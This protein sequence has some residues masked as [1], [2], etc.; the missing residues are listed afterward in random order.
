M[1]K[2][3]VFL[4]HDIFRNSFK[5]RSLKR[6]LPK[7]RQF[8]AEALEAR[9]LM[10]S[11]VHADAIFAPGTPTD[12]I[13]RVHDALGA[14]HQDDAFQL[15][16]IRWT[17]TASGPSPNLGD[18]VTLTWSIVADGTPTDTA[19]V[20][21]NL[22]A[23]LDGIYGGGA[24]P[25][26]TRPW[27]PIFQ[28][29]YDRWSALTG[30]NYVYEPNDDGAPVGGANSFGVLGVRGDVRI[31]GQLIDGNSGILAYNYFPSATSSLAGDMMIDTGDNFYA[32]N[33]GG[34][35]LALRN[36]L[37][38]EAGHGLGLRHTEPVDGS[39]LMEPFIN[40]GFDGPQHDDILGAHRLY[41]DANEPN[42]NSVTATDVG[43]LA[44]AAPLHIQ[45]NS[46]DD[47]GDVDVFKF[48]VF[49]AG[50][51]NATITPAGRQYSEGPQGGPYNPF[52]SNTLGD[53]TISVLDSTGNVMSTINSGPAGAVE[54]IANLE[55]PG[56]GE[57][58]VRITSSSDNIQPYNLSLAVMAEPEPPRLL[59]VQANDGSLVVDGQVRHAAPR[60]LRV[61]FEGGSNLNPATLSSGIRITRSG[62][63]GN[64]TD[65][66][67]TVIVP[68]FIGLGD[69]ANVV[70]IRFAEPLTD[71]HYRLEILGTTANPLR[72]VNGKA[73]N[74]GDS[75]AVIDFR[76]DLG[77]Q[78]VAVVPQPI[79]RVG[80][81]LVQHANR[82]V[83]HFNEDTLDR[84]KAENPAFYQ[85]VKTT[86][87][88]T[89]ATLTGDD[90]TVILPTSV[91]Y[92]RLNNTATLDFPVNAIDTAI[93]RLRVG[94]AQGDDST[95]STAIK[96]GTLY[97]TA[98]DF[99]TTGYIGDAAS[100]STNVNDVDLYRF[101][102]STATTVNA[103][104]APQAGH[105]TTVRLFNSAGVQIAGANN[106]GAGVADTLAF[107]LP[108]AGTY[109]L[110]VS[111]DGNTG[112]D[113]TNGSGAAGGTTTGSYLLEVDV[114]ASLPVNDNN[115]SLATA[116]E[117]GALGAF[118]QVINSTIT[119][120][121]IQMRPLPGG[122][123]EPGH[124][125][126]PVESHG[127]GTG[128]GPFTPGASPVINYTFNKTTPYGS[129]Q[130]NAL[131]NDI[132]AEQM[133]RA[134]E[135]FE[136]YSAILGVQFREQPAG[137]IWVI[138]GDLRAASPFL[139]VGPGGVG[140][141][142][143]GNLVIMDAAEGWPAD[144]LYG[145]PWFGVAF[146]E[147][148]HALGLGHAYDIPAIMGGG[149]PGEQVYPTDYDIVH[150][151]RLY[152]PDSDDVDLYEFTLPEAGRFSAETVAERQTPTSN[153]N[154]VLKLFDATGK[155][156]AQNDDYF[157]NDSFMDL[158]LPAGTYFLG[159]SS[160]GNSDYDP[161]VSN[162]GGGGETDGAYQLKINFAPSTTSAGLM[163]VTGTSLDGDADGLPGGVFDFWFEG[164]TAAN[165]I[166]VDKANDANGGVVDGNG[167]L[168]NPYDE[169]DFALTQAAAQLALPANA[170]QRRV[171]RVVGNGGT[172][173]DLST[174]L[175][176]RPYLIGR[177]GSS[178]L[179]DGGN[180]L[181]PKDV[182]MMIDEG[183]VLKFKRS[184]IDLGTSSVGLD[185]S[186]GALQVLGTPEN[187]VHLTSYHND[188]VGGNSDSAAP[189]VVAPGNWGGIIFRQDAGYREDDRTG[190]PAQAGVFLNS[191]NQAQL[192]YGG[193]GVTI[194]SGTEQVS[195]VHLLE[196]RPAVW[197]STL[198][199]NT[200]PAISATPNSFDDR[201]GRI[202]PDLHDNNLANNG[203]NGVFL[204]TATPD[205][206]L[207]NRLDKFAR[208]DDTDIVH[209]ISE[210][211][212]IN[213][214]PG[215]PF[216]TTARLDARLKIDPGI[217]VK[218]QGT[219]IETEF[220]ATLIA[221]GT[222]AEPIV[223]TSIKDDR[224]GFGDRFDT[225][226]DGTATLP[227]AADWSGLV[228][229][230]NTIGSID[231]ATM[232]F[233]GGS[234]AIRGGFDYFNTIEVHQADVRLTNSRLENNADGAAATNR[235]GLGTNRDATIFVR[236]AQ[237]VIVN[238]TM[239]GNAGH[240]ISINANSMQSW[241]MADPGRSTG[242][243]NVFDGLS[244]NRG[245]MV[246]LN[247]L[248]GNGVNGMEV[249]AEEI[250]IDAVWDDTDIVHVV[251]N[252]IVVNNLH[253]ATSLRLQSSETESLVVKLMGT[254]AGFTA[255]GSRLDI[256]D[257]IGGTVQVVG[258]SGHPV[259][260][261]SLLDCSVG[262][263][264]DPFGR[265]MTD[266]DG[267]GSCDAGSP[268]AVPYADVIVVMDETITMGPIQAF[269]EQFILDLEAGLL[270]AG[271][272]STSA[273]GNRYG[274]LGFGGTYAAN[275]TW[276]D[277]HVI[278]VGPGNNPWGTAQEYVAAAQTLVTNGT[279]EDGYLAMDLMFQSY[280]TRP[281]AA[282]FVI[283]A[284]DE[285][286]DVT[287][288][289]LTYAS[290]LANLQAGGFKLQGII[291]VDIADPTNMQA[292]ALDAQQNAYTDNGAGGFNVVPNGQFTGSIGTTIPDYADMVF[293]TGGTVGDIELIANSAQQAQI[294]SQVL[295]SS[296]IGQISG[297]RAAAGDWRSVK[298]DKYSNDRNVAMVLER[299]EALTDGVDQNS[300]PD[301]AQFVGKLAKDEKS[302]DDNL[303][304]GF[305]VNGFIALDDPTDVDVYSFEAQ[306]GS[307][308]WLDIDRTAMH[309]DS[310]LELVDFDGNVVAS[311]NAGVL[312]GGALDLV[313]DP[314]FGGD[315]FT[316]NRHDVGQGIIYDEGFRFTLPG[317]PAQRATYFVRVRSAGGLSHAVNTN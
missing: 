290:T 116:T 233:A 176:N 86:N 80:G 182:T 230:P 229:R 27:F 5:R 201:L 283:I 13:D 284:S 316:S 63:D 24:G 203:L 280:V 136:L 76:L 253:T 43:T 128:V 257:R 197:R 149:L 270:A 122:E 137:G 145:G 210:N 276:E 252:E 94:A 90:D 275:P 52:N 167:T 62:R 305:E 10:A 183:A 302:G 84:T 51:L 189:E 238:N 191:I 12:Y 272:G 111:S 212:I 56:G 104:V 222:P 66:D 185:R 53:L 265:P 314:V 151:K 103:R 97:N 237:P 107:A 282:K 92:D 250:T 160:T 307:E 132:T 248:G 277:G 310:V 168:A 292:I 146:H 156:V 288:P 218:L 75:D 74:D 28:Q 50:L 268:A 159:V 121:N 102:V 165:T 179:V 266:T 192:T 72:G 99:S 262:A 271:I 46:I 195:I 120:P 109:Y 30:I 306:P 196:A 278:P 221:E 106:G 3:R 204:E 264:F 139:P 175:D 303:R 78:V 247:R 169:I 115:S 260:L 118:Q 49:N 16:P 142:N 73:F 249:R 223:F 254:N 26:S 17:Q 269:S 148:G 234:S 42:E 285:D 88:A 130:G 135:I 281:E 194:N 296:I 225:N 59:A 91:V 236:G 216:Q 123:D 161:L 188:G 246:R 117:I 164:N 100:T 2:R 68:G 205:G 38:H 25:V 55:L 206:Q 255:N 202:G 83:V 190:A 208:F 177:V 261:T 138:T 315:F 60:E 112:Y 244:D 40:L 267:S 232:S 57:Y 273:G 211:L 7:K 258:T 147:I 23:F 289:S 41:G 166:Y 224:Y 81:A 125:D 34:T 96:L 61:Y 304:L 140:G 241:V 154:T 297:N 101:E 79:E 240:A 242:P 239:L 98:E 4:H 198:A 87:A 93:Y 11:D 1:A 200:G 215:G 58:Y 251:R 207:V 54:A 113:I 279:T 186:N 312:T 131:Y 174:F 213:G 85:L 313:K 48:R 44:E 245:P 228:F 14:S 64:F 309:L 95:R 127:A 31:G 311:S 317:N 294:F 178:D 105:N 133:D 141:V 153:L 47:D 32:N 20:N 291:S 67:E 298:F 293:A 9:I 243:A 220:G 199:N 184:R 71:D 119:A 259:V 256:D 170:G 8:Q 33:A 227:A 308:V 70:I 22:I 36:I 143:S 162:S 286:R 180:L 134:R 124:R 45:G 37:M 219:R 89:G 65:G 108:G 231:H 300:V 263:G 18:Q 171:V 82:I 144:S 173:G 15:N 39:K 299:E 181:I 172:D 214:E 287:D 19:G 226:N 274:L 69:T 77:A 21:S 301:D 35:N 6:S 29:S 163:D 235:L 110:G 187:N 157:S 158:D 152:R 193:G 155:V 217:T 295:V 209:I 129:Y 150:L 126:I 114:T